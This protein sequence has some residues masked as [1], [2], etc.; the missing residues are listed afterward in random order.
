MEK[1]QPFTPLPEFISSTK[2]KAS[3]DFDKWPFHHGRQSLWQI[4]IC[5]VLSEK[6]S[7]LMLGIFTWVLGPRERRFLIGVSRTLLKKDWFM[8]QNRDKNM[9]N[10]NCPGKASKCHSCLQ[11]I[12]ATGT[13]VWAEP[14]DYSLVLWAKMDEMDEWPEFSF[15]FFLKTSVRNSKVLIICSRTSLVF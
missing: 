15:H 1:G 13:S 4:S 2:L 12:S 5:L 9:L 6:D 3:G 7:C 10:Q 11:F 8:T 14:R